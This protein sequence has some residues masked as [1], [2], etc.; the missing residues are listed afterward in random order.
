MAKVLITP[1]LFEKIRKTFK[2]NANKVI[3]LLE[4]LEDNPKKG[5]EVGC[6]GGIVIKEIRYKVYR[7]YFIS[8]GYKIKFLKSGELT[9]LL[10]KFVRMSDKDTQQK[11]INEIKNVLRN[12]GQEGF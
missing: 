12:L 10:I 2:G 11:V 9:D 1:S 5:K 6:V 7:F 8:D 3:D 4:T